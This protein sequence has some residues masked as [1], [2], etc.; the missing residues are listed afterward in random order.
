MASWQHLLHVSVCSPHVLHVFPTFRFH[1]DSL[2]E[3]HGSRG[4]G[5]PVPWRP[6]LTGLSRALFWTLR[7]EVGIGC[8]TSGHCRQF[9]LPARRYDICS[10]LIQQTLIEHY[11][12]PGWCRVLES[13]RSKKYILAPLAFKFPPE[14]K[15]AHSLSLGNWLHE[16]RTAE[17]AKVRGCNCR[18]QPAVEGREAQG[19]QK[20]A[21][22]SGVRLH[23]CSRYSEGPDVVGF[24]SRSR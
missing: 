19:L 12:V 10:W 20:R 4:R 7:E 14:T 21:R 18:K 23:F 5:L 24:R 6:V 17:M 2:C 15:K 9:T 8:H 11:Y 22:D 3:V 1:T 13:E 16:R